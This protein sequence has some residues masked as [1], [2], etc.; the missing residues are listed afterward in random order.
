MHCIVHA[1][2]LAA[3]KL[4]SELNDVM[5]GAVKISNYIC[6]RVLHLRLF[7]ALSESMGSQHPQLIFHAEMIR[8]SRGR[9][10][11][12]LFDLRDEANK[13]LRE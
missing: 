5:I 13:V 8:F 1:E 11:A 7:E 4:S 2:S 12:R 3:Q 9:V 10:L 6:D